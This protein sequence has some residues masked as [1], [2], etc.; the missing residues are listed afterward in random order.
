MKRGLVFGM[1]I[2]IVMMGFALIGGDVAAKEPKAIKWYVDDD[3]GSSQDGS[4]EYPFATIQE[5]V[6]AAAAGDEVNV[7]PGMYIESV[8]I[9]KSIKLKGKDA[10]IMCPTTPEVAYVDESSKM[11][12]YLVGIF[13]G[14]YDV[15]SNTYSGPGTVSVEISGFIVDAN[16]YS[17]AGRWCSILLRNANKDDGKSKIHKCDVI[18]TNVDGKETFG[19]LGYGTMD[20]EI[21]DNLVNQFARGGIGMYSGHAKIEKNVVIGP[22]LGVPVTWAPNGIQVGYG[23]SAKIKDNEVTGCGWPGTAWAGTG[24]LIVDT[25][26]VKIEKNYVHDNETAIGVV[27]FPESLYGSVWSGVVSNIE[28]KKNIVEDNEWGIDIANECNNVKVEKNEVYDNTYDGIDVWTYSGL[29]P[30][31]SNIKIEKNSIVGNGGDGLWVGSTVTQ[32]VDAEKNWWGAADGPSGDGPGS[33]DTVIGNADYE[34]WLTKQ[35]KQP[36]S[37]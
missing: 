14:S 16:D 6:D 9:T 20:V 34:P 23:A 35:P 24:I 5:G 29:V 4:K 21:K 15:D 36:R 25:S 22:G 27:D 11:Y 2:L 17:P 19:I 10:T 12:E 3:A 32:I 26:D 7:E 31:P 18:N 13:G 8:T 30:P 1:T 37:H 33:G 28:V